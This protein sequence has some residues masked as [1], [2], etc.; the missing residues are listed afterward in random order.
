MTVQSTDIP[1]ARLKQS[2][3]IVARI[4]CDDL[5]LLAGAILGWNLYALLFQDVSPR[6]FLVRVLTV[7]IALA[8]IVVRFFYVRAGPTGF[9]AIH[10]P[11]VR[12]RLSVIAISAILLGIAYFGKSSL[13]F[14]LTKMFVFL[15]GGY[16]AGKHAK[17][18]RFKYLRE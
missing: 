11:E 12:Y 5:A 1:F 9:L 16:Y 7:V 15:S 8:V 6:I 3:K 13:F 10:Q 18:S 14:E 17:H 2:L 4:L